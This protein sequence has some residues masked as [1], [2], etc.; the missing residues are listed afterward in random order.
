M[1]QE[2]VKIATAAR[3]IM[4]FLGTGG[5]IFKN[6]FLDLKKKKIISCLSVLLFGRTVMGGTNVTPLNK[7]V[8]YK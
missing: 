6:K 7:E 1:Q 4:P 8:L 5:A 3:L 2:A